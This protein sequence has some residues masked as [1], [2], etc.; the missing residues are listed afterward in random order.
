MFSYTFFADKE[1]QF[2]RES[3]DE[4]VGRSWHFGRDGGPA[5]LVVSTWVAGTGATKVAGVWNAGATP[6]DTHSQPDP[7][8]FP[9]P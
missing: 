4:T 9:R 5:N 2:R 8:F 1:F 7:L 6:R 3:S